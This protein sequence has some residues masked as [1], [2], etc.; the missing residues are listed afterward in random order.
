LWQINNGFMRK[1]FI[2]FLCLLFG[3]GQVLG[4]T[5]TQVT[6]TLT[7]GVYLLVGDAASGTDGIMLNTANAS[8]YINYTTVSN[9]TATITS[10]VTSA[11]EF[12]ITVSGS[13]I[14][15]YNAS[16]GYVSWGGSGNTGNT[17]N[18]VNTTTPGDNET[19]TASLSGGFWVLRNKSTTG[20]MLQWNS[21]AT[22][23]AAYLSASGQRDLKLYKKE[24]TCTAPTL[25][26]SG[27]ST[28]NI[29][30]TGVSF[31][32]AAGGG[33]AALLV[34]RATA[35]AN[36]APVSGTAYTGNTDFSAA[37][38]INANNKVVYAGAANGVN[39]IT[40]L[41]PGTQY[42][43]TAYAF[44]TTDNCYNTS[45]PASVAFYT[46]STQPSAQPATFNAVAAAHD[47]VNLSFSAANTLSNAAGYLVLQKANSAPT[48]V[49]VNA[50]AY[51]VGATI[52]DATV[53]AIVTTASATSQSITGLSPLNTYYYTI[54]PFNW[55]GSNAPT[56]NYNTS[57]TMTASATTPNGPSAASD[58]V[59]NA[60]AAFYTAN[61]DYLQYQ[62]ST[63]TAIGSGAVAV[64]ALQLRDGGTAA[65]DADALPT[66]LTALTINYTGAANTIR[67]AA[68]FD[69][70]TKVAEVTAGANAISFTGLTGLNAADNG[71]KNFTL[72]VSFNTAVTDNDKLIFTV[73]SAATAANT[74]S[75]QFAAGNAGAANSDNNTS[76]DNNR[77][78][79]TATKIAFTT[80]ATNTNLNAVMTPNPVISALDVNNNIDLDATGSVSLT[81]SGTL[82]TSP[83]T[84]TLTNGQATFTAITHTA[85]GTG[86][87]LNAQSGS[88]TTVNSAAFN[89]HTIPYANGDYRTT[90]DGNWPNTTGTW[91][92]MTNGVWASATRPS[93]SY[94][95]GRLYIQ[96]TISTSG[97]FSSPSISILE[98]GKFTVNASSTIA[99]LKVYSGGTFEAANSMTMSASASAKNVVVE[100]GGKFVLNAATLTS[101]GTGS[102]IWN[103]NED[104]QSGSILE[105]RNWN[106]SASSG[107]QRL[108]YSTPQVSANANGYFFGNIHYYGAQTVTFAFLN[109]F[110][111]LKLC[112]NNLMIESAGSG[113]IALST[114]TAN[115]EI[116]GSLIINNGNFSASIPA[117]GSNT[118]NIHGNLEVKSGA[119]F[120]INQQ[121]VAANSSVLL[122]GDL[123]VQGTLEGSNSNTT[124]TNAIIFNK[125]G[126]QSIDIDGTLNNHVTFQVNSGAELVLPQNLDLTNA[127]NT[128]EILNGGTLNFNGFNVTGAGSLIN[129]AGGTLKITS[130]QGI[131]SAGTTG[132]VH[133]TT[134]NYNSGGTYMYVGA[135]SQSTG[136][137]MPASVANVVVNNTNGVQFSQATTL[138]GNLNLVNGLI[139][140][141]ATNALTLSTDATVT[142][143]NA[144]SYIN[145]PVV[146]NT[147]SVTAKTLPVGKNGVYAPVIL[148][149]SVS[150]AATFVAEYFNGAAT[151]PDAGTYAS[152]SNIQSIDNFQY[153]NVNRSSGSATA[154]LTLPF[155]SSSNIPDLS[156]ALVAHYNGSAWENAGN[157]GTSGSVSGGTV[158]SNALNTFSPFTV[159]ILNST[160]LPVGLDDF[161]VEKAT[162]S[163]NLSWH[164]PTETPGSKYL[165]ERSNN[166]VTFEA[167]ASLN[168]TGKES[169][170]TYADKG[171]KA[172]DN[173]YRLTLVDRDGATTVS[174][175]KQIFIKAAAEAILVYPNP[176]SKAVNLAGLTAEDVVNVY[177]VTGTLVQSVTATGKTLSID[178]CNV[179]EGVY[180][181]QVVHSGKIIA[182]EKLVIVK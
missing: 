11:N 128:L 65:P 37:T 124:A 180:T 117:S 175:V 93:G 129:N 142:G 99:D 136:N 78:E 166:G 29:S 145:G 97:S 131:T 68:L 105:I 85:L 109:G 38:G 122:G 87:M 116:G 41:S 118:H 164:N 108:V 120:R 70:A 76:N 103:G 146:Q 4:Q 52:G 155:Q 173:Y 88:F 121:S 21:S 152:G 113:V 182:K 178:L 31:S 167:I 95:G 130:P 119:T 26:T 174:K 17:A 66:Q 58:I 154:S 53:A 86:L 51:T 57:N 77:L 143:G 47:Q 127:R 110:N 50:T 170:Y 101:N 15:I 161:K 177:N 30:N 92:L 169:K 46:L 176:A 134:R 16:A 132:N 35:Q 79:V 179:A 153:W 32:W 55:N 34:L 149:P 107:A 54:V 25:Q 5:Y 84:A 3:A 71:T 43:A 10:G 162:A 56:Y 123:L 60:G 6:T 150:T 1:N 40:N 159:G 98:N 8:P 151:T 9:P 89:I 160:P 22:R 139:G 91:E 158:T 140:N 14:T 59:N 7:D 102:S 96:H 157:A 137:G 36:A 112:E 44:N 181:V 49:P 148:T 111:A 63:I 135:A 168:A 18:F 114:T 61:I 24:A 115:A 90:S 100:S 62:S 69:G 33:D 45:S 42:T 67:K 28:A 2:L 147:N 106:Y 104:F 125:T 163:V 73:A 82:A 126:T 172:G 12:T 48:G 19:W 83:L 133:T 81:S 171:Y 20:R 138:T 141:T 80:N 23:F 165:V 39:G 27:L 74:V 72:A 156:R 13:D 64:M 144:N 94:S 75:S